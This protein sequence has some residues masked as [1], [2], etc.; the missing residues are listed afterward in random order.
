VVRTPRRPASAPARALGAD[1]ALPFAGSTARVAVGVIGVVAAVLSLYMG[2][3][4]EQARGPYAIYGEM[5]LQDA[6]GV[7]NPGNIYP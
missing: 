7:Y 4:K 2:F 3:M 5:T 6:H 1:A